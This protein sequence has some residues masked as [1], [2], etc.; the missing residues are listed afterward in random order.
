MQQAIQ[1]V[2]LSFSNSSSNNTSSTENIQI[3][4]LHVVEEIHIRIPSLYFSLLMKMMNLKLKK[5]KI[6]KGTR[7]SWLAIRAT[8]D[9]RIY[10][11]PFLL[12]A[13]AWIS[14]TMAMSHYYVGFI[15]AFAACRAESITVIAAVFFLSSGRSIRFF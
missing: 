8:I 7:D 3:I 11:S 12:A 13:A 6:R 14:R 15:A 5:D 9:M 10:T 4:L 1:L 2:N